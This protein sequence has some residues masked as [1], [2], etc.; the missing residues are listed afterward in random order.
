MKRTIYI[1]SLTIVLVMMLVYERDIMFYDDAFTDTRTVSTLMPKLA[2][3]FFSLLGVAFSFSRALKTK[4]AKQYTMLMIVVYAITVFFS[5][6]Y[7]L[8]SRDEYITIILPLLLFYLMSLSSYNIKNDQLIIWGVSIMVVLLSLNYIAGYTENIFGT[9]NSTTASYHILYFLPFLFCHKNRILRIV[10]A[11]IIVVI[12][13]LSLKRGGLLA[14]FAAIVVYLY[15]TQFSFKGRRLNTWGILMTA[16]SVAGIVYLY[17]KIDENVVDG[18]LTT[19]LDSMNETGGSG[20]LEVYKGYLDFIAND[21]FSSYIVG[22]GWWGTMRDSRVGVTCHN[23]FL[24]CFID[25]GIIGFA[26]YIAFIVSLIKLCAKMIRAK[27]EYAPAMAAALAMFFVNSMVAHILIYPKFSM[28][29]AL[30]WG[31][32]V[33]SSRKIKYN[34]IIGHENRIVNISRS[35]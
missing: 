3:L 26:L 4:V 12:V 29:F 34:K 21:D 10:F 23:D 30:F 11:V 13:M 31:F 18:L 24:E 6:I 25:F 9:L 35:L 2:M 14:A 32:I 7:P 5:L 1:A 15:V 8:T 16:V 19:R 28:I 27:H 33:S 22:H 20:R 17:L